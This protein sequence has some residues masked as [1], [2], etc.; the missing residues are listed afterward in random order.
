MRD[1]LI[2]RADLPQQGCRVA[3]IGRMGA[4]W[5]ATAGLVVTW[6]GRRRVQTCAAAGM[7]TLPAGCFITALPP[8]STSLH[9]VPV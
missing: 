5:A 4:R 9:P 6:S 3:V 2:R 8:Y 7:V 1:D